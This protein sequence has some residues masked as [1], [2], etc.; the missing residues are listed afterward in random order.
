M[1]YIN[2]VTSNPFWSKLKDAWTATFN[3]DSE[4][5][6]RRSRFHKHPQVENHDNFTSIRTE[7]EVLPGSITTEVAEKLSKDIS[8]IFDRA[9][10]EAQHCIREAVRKSSEAKSRIQSDHN[11]IDR[12]KPRKT[13]DSPDIEKEAAIE[14]HLMKYRS[15]ILNCVKATDLIAFYDLFTSVQTKQLR[16]LYRRNPAEATEKAFEEISLIQ[17]QPDKYR[18]LVSALND[19]GYTKIVQILKGQIVPVGSRHREAIRHSA[20]HIFQRLNVTEILPYLYAKFVISEEDKQ[21]IQRTEKNESVGAAAM[22]LLDILPNRHEEWYRLFLESL[23]ESGHSDIVHIIEA[24]VTDTAEHYYL[25]KNNL[26]GGSHETDYFNPNLINST[27]LFKS[28]D[29]PNAD[30][31]LQKNLSNESRP[32]SPASNLSDAGSDAPSCVPIDKRSQRKA[33]NR[34]LLAAATRTFTSA[35]PVDES[36]WHK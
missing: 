10:Q 3:S 9:N 13:Y 28:K 6:E 31:Y 8:K 21:Q 25:A 27:E 14:D 30:I 17:N 20:K 33:R 23:N 35:L 32:L 2:K 22:E 16:C 36:G 34:V 1:D 18:R 11:P 12:S 29:D 5:Y 19:T 15:Y 26:D 4:K 7:F 24:E